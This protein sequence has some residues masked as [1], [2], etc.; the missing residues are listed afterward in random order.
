[1]TLA[2]GETVAISIANMAGEP[3]SL[4]GGMQIARLQLL[5]RPVVQKL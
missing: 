1:M 5:H 2:R 4:I 3:T